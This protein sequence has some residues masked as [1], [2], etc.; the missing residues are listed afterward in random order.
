MKF[1]VSFHQVLILAE[2]KFVLAYGQRITKRQSRSV[3]FFLNFLLENVTLSFQIVLWQSF[4]KHFSFYLCRISSIVLEQ[5]SSLFRLFFIRLSRN[6]RP[7]LLHPLA[8]PTKFL[9]FFESLKIL[10]MERIVGGKLE[11]RPCKGRIAISRHKWALHD[12]VIES[13]I[14][15]L[16][17]SGKI[18]SHIR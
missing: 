13:R 11:I 7:A 1:D 15:R 9:I 16:R 18:S 8:T 6:V 4:A 14:R 3:L 12:W 5:V 17:H 2:L 10:L